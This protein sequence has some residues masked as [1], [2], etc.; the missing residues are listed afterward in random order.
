MTSQCKIYINSSVFKPDL[1]SLLLFFSQ[2]EKNSG[3]QTISNF[4][5]STK[6]CKFWSK[7]GFH[8]KT[9][10]RRAVGDKALLCDIRIPHRFLHR[11]FFP[12]FCPWHIYSE[13]A[14]GAALMIMNTVETT[15]K[16]IKS[17]TINPASILLAHMLI[18]T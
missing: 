7:K 4:K 14:L 1:L 15:S 9:I 8:K 16:L 2:E 6:G 12:S 17:P 5:P 13:C 18:Q 3:H 11:F 10:W